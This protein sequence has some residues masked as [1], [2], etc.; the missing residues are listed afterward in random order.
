MV[1]RPDTRIEDGELVRRAQHG[2]AWAREALFRRYAARVTRLVTRLLS[3]TADADDVVQDTF[4]E[5][6]RD[7]DR[8]RD[9]DAFRSWLFRIAVN[10]VKKFARRRKLVRLLGL[11]SGIDDATLVQLLA[12]DAGPDVVAEIAWL[13]GRLARLPTEV[14]IAWM[15][16]HVEGETLE[17]VAALSGCSLATAKRRVS[18][19]EV[20]LRSHIERGPA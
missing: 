7:I 5:A 18:A 1:P 19:G 6:L 17:E 10:R 2:D 15:L 4:A 12:P 16:R 13:D 8:L 14:R 20:A 3:R 11:D 9:P